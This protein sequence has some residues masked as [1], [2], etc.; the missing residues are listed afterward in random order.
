MIGKLRSQEPYNRGNEV[1]TTLKEGANKGKQ[2]SG[3][4]SIDDNKETTSAD[5]K[6]KCRATTGLTSGKTTASS[7]VLPKEDSVDS[8]DR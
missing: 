3:V 1:E 4:L 8:S 6:N 7:G 5:S 2:D